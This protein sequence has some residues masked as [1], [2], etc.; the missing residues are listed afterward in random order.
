MSE[1]EAEG[2]LT[3]DA[4]LIADDSDIDASEAVTPEAKRLRESTTALTLAK[5]GVGDLDSDASLKTLMLAN[6]KIRHD[7][8]GNV[9]SSL[10]S[11]GNKVNEHSKE[12]VRLKKAIDENERG[13]R[14]MRRRSGGT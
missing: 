4:V 11:L 8:M 14:T 7:Q 5:Q 1:M 9:T 12:L 2:Y 10:N 3:A 13:R 6:F